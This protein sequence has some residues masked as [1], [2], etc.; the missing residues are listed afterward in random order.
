MRHPALNPVYLHRA[1]PQHRIGEVLAPSQQRPAP[2]RQLVEAER[3][4]QAIIRA[5]VQAFAPAPQHYLSPVSTS[6]A[7]P[8]E[9]PAHLSQHLSPVLL[10]KTK[11]QHNQV[12]PV[13]SAHVSAPV[14]HPP[15]NP[16]HALPASTLFAGTESKCR[17]VF[18]NQNSHQVPSFIARNAQP[19]LH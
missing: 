3:L 15:P 9:L 13:L 5:V 4:Q 17:I 16:L 6:T 12:W 11:V 19:K 2:R 8:S 18:H 14:R 1:M 7:V 10:R